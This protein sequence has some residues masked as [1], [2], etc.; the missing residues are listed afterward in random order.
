MQREHV[1]WSICA[2]TVG[3]GEKVVADVRVFAVWRRA[4]SLP[5]KGLFRQN[6]VGQREA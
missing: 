4:V 1:P 2:I 6:H 5:G 3:V